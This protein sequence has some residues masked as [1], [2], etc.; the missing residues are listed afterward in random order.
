MKFVV[1]GE[2]WG[3]HPSSTQHLFKHIGERHQVFW[4]NSIG[5]RA[6][7]LAVKDIKRVW[8]K[9][10]LMLTKSTPD[11]E[12]AIPEKFS[13]LNPKLLPW[14]LNSLAYRFNRRQIR[15]ELAQLGD[16]PIIYWLSL[17][18]AIR[19]I[20]P[21]PQDKVVYYCGDDFTG[22][23]GV[24][25]HMAK[26]TEQ[27][28]VERAD[29]IYV[30]SQYLMRKMPRE[31]TQLLEHGVDFELFSTPVAKH[32]KMPEADNVIGFYGSISDWLDTSLLLELVHKRPNYKLV[33]VG[34][35]RTDIDEL[36]K[37]PNVIHIDAVQHCELV[38]FAQHWDVALLPF[39]DN[40]QIR[41]CDPL[42]LKEYL[43]CGKPI[44]ATNFPAVQRFCSSVLVANDRKG[45]IERVDQAMEISHS[46]EIQWRSVSKQQ[47]QSHS[48]SNKVKFL[49]HELSF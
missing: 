7:S 42:K 6:P 9:A 16:E 35:V 19:V 12:K 23:A 2:D 5:L 8:Q 41:A 29:Q 15:K 36:L 14:H 3:K 44:V 26:I 1:F 25:H 27:E 31:K 43:A 32:P 17:P 30:A 40:K 39:V 20:E 38:Q 21:R 4:F 24:D 37:M 10:R 18:S 49:Q 48:W 33:L 46:P 13:V 47:V 11:T 28:L 22:L 45:F 34:E